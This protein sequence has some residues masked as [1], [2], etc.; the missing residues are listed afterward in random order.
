MP[1]MFEVGVVVGVF[2]E[3][4]AWILFAWWLKNNFDITPKTPPKES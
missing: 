3:G 1:M 2:L 4:A